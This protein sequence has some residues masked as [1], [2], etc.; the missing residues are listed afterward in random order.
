MS[1]F[2]IVT[3]LMLRIK[4]FQMTNKSLIIAHRGESFEAPENTLAAINLAWK[5][6]AEAVEVDI[7]LSKDKQIVVIHD[8]NTKRTGGVSKKVSAQSLHELKDLDFGKF[9]GKKWISEKIPTLEE[10]LSSVPS[11]KKIILDIKC[12][13][14]IIPSLKKDIDNSGLDIDQ[15]ELV[16]FK[17]KT[18]VTIKKTFPEN[19]VL[20]CHNLDYNIIR[21][22]VKPNINLLIKRAFDNSLNGIDVWDSDLISKSIVES[23]KNLGLKIYVWT[24]NDLERAKR[25][26]ELGVDGINSD[27]P[28]WLT[29][30][31]FNT[32]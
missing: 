19:I 23:I 28:S 6:N 16:G 20:W 17:F 11:N 31:L 10:V 26:I 25:L 2:I 22:I 7:Q 13:L 4:C 29:N 32:I 9:K 14:D 5:R 8:T 21:K 1:L 15:I 30:N 27:K 24:V 18:M 3:I 12:G